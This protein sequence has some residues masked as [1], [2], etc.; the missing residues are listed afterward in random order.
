[1][2]SLRLIIV[3]TFVLAAGAFLGMP[4][5]LKSLGLHPDYTGARVEMRGGRALVI[6]TSQSVLAPGTAATGVFA[7]EMTGPYYVFTDAGLHV[8]IASIKG[9][10]VPIDPLSF[11]WFI[12]SPDD[13]RFKGDA[14]LQQKVA[15]SQRIDEIDFASYDLV[16]LAGGWG[17]AYDLGT[18]DMLGAKLTEAWKAGRVVGGVCH[19]PLGLLRALDETGSPLVKGRRVTGVSDKQVQELGISITPMHPERELRAAGARY[20]SATAFRD[21]FANHVVED[22]RLITGQNQNAALEV[23]ARM[24]IAA[25]AA[26]PR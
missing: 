2:R 21:V 10:P 16:Y 26:R 14:S 1:M 18:S 17:A 13:K 12:E 24:V 8:D 11:V 22:G 25:Q 20:E 19:G 9:G 7:S 3:V 23:A 15:Q 4:P 6:T 5:L